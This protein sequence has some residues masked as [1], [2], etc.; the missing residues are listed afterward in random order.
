M[1]EQEE[2]V[3]V[4]HLTAVSGTLGR[5]NGEGKTVLVIEDNELNMQMFAALLVAHRYNVLQALNGPEGWR[6]A[7]ETRP[8]LVIMDIQLPGVSGLE[9]TQWFRNHET[10]KFVPVVAVTAF[11]TEGNKKVYLKAGCDALVSKPISIVDFMQTVAR[12]AGTADEPS[13]VL[14]MSAGELPHRA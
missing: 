9:V 2:G 11:G 1:H 4:T 8:D 14:P 3:D 12:F 7:Q 10:L 6:L 5:V 13:K